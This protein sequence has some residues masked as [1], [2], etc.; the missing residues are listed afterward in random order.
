MSTCMIV[1]AGDI[2]EYWFKKLPVDSYI[3]VDGGFAF[4]DE[5]NV[6]PCLVLG[7]FDSLGYIPKVE[8]I[9]VHPAQK[10]E[11]DMILAVENAAKSWETVYILGALGGRR[12][13]HSLANV[14]MLVYSAKLG[15]R[16]IILDDHCIMFAVSSER[17]VISSNGEI[18]IGKKTVF[19]GGSFDCA[20][21]NIYLSV[22]AVNECEGVTLKGCKYEVEKGSLSYDFPLGVSNEFCGSKDC[23]IS[24]EKG[25]L[26]VCIE[27]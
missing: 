26:I 13:G 25:I 16:P 2:S 11:T 22:F 3:A 1:G 5:R 4:L 17:A 19:T 8:N 10:D 15:L 9:D 12:F 24:V 14:Q 18:S 21:E 27:I 7:D 23:E 6:K 20:D